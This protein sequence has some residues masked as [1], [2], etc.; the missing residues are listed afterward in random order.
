[1]LP[2]RA[3]SFLLT[4]VALTMVIAGCAGPTTQA[5]S[6]TTA[7]AEAPLRPAG[8]RGTWQGSFLHPGADYTSP[9][10]SNLTLE[11]R[12]DSTYTLKLGSRAAQTGT[13]TTQGNRVVLNDSSGSRMTLMQSGDSLYGVMKDNATGRATTMNLEKQESGASRLA[14]TRTR[15]CQ[16][17]GGTYAQGVC[18]AADDTAALA[19]RCEARGGTFFPGGNYCEVPAGGLRPR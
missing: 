15:L 3:V 9:H 6:G 12:E 14:A 5:G 16:T 8:L 10:N 7:S 13:I 11:V 2:H 1:M 19:A 4:G 17:A 18:Q